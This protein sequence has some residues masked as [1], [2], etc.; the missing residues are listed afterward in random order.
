V[1]GR[2]AS[3]ILAISAYPAIRLAH[4]AVARAFALMSF[5][6]RHGTHHDSCAQTRSVGPQVYTWYTP[7]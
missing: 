6:P 3:R 5:M 4:D 7:M 2:V 1:A